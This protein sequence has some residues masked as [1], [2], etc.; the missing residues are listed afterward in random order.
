[1]G[2]QQSDERSKKISWLIEENKK[3]Q[4]EFLI[5][6]LEVALYRIVINAKEMDTNKFE[7][8]EYFTI[9]DRRLDKCGN[10]DIRCG[11][12]IE[13]FLYSK[14]KNKVAECRS[15][16]L[17]YKIKCIDY[18][19]R[20]FELSD[21]SSLI[22]GIESPISELLRDMGEKYNN[23]NITASASMYLDKPIKDNPEISIYKVNP[24]IGEDVYALSYDNG[25]FNITMAWQSE[26]S[27]KS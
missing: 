20:S 8:G 6:K 4:V 26:E 15:D 1:M 5:D 24:E 19:G 7:I 23:I 21:S 12:N 11:Y 3:R 14:Y 10:E 16:P 27:S 9:I 22:G 13:I 17:S 18:S 2:G 25:R